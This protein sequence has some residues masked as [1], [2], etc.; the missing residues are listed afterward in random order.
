MEFTANHMI[1]NVPGADSDDQTPTPVQGG[2]LGTGSEVTDGVGLGGGTVGGAVDESTLSVWYTAAAGGVVPDLATLDTDYCVVDTITLASSTTGDE[3]VVGGTTYTAGTTES[4]STNQYDCSGSDTA[5][6][7]S[8]AACIDSA[9][10]GTDN[11][12]AS[13]SAGVVYCTRATAGTPTTITE[14]ETTITLDF[15]VIL[16]IS[17]GGIANDDEVTASYTYDST[18]SGDAYTV[19]TPSVIASADY[20]DNYALVCELSNQSYTN[21]YIVY[22]INNCLPMPDP[23]AIP[24]EWPGET[25]LSALIEGS[26]DPADGLSMDY[27]PVEAWIGIT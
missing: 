4:L 1:W 17:T 19:I 16:E 12:D 14:A 27:A 9:T 22:K 10:Y 7:T 25:V 11:V 24:G 2:Y 26:F 6:A 3:V 15:Q 5:D 21:P 20:A 18:D 13:S 8:L 23:V